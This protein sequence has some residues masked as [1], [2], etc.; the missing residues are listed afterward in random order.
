MMFSKKI[1]NGKSNIFPCRFP[2]TEMTALA[3]YKSAPRFVAFSQK[4]GM[5]INMKKRKVTL[6][7]LL[8][9][10]ATLLAIDSFKN[11]HYN[12]TQITTTHPESTVN[13]EDNAATKNF[14]SSSLPSIAQENKTVKFYYMNES[15]EVGKTAYNIAPYI[16]PRF[17]E[18]YDDK[19]EKNF[20]VYYADRVLGYQAYLTNV[21]FI[22]YDKKQNQFSANKAYSP[23]SITIDKNTDSL[24]LQ[25]GNYA[26][27]LDKQEIMKKVYK[28]NSNLK[29]ST[30]ELLNVGH[31]DLFPSYIQS[32]DLDGD[33]YEE[34]LIEYV[35]KNI[36]YG[37]YLTSILVVVDYK[38]NFNI[39]D[40]YCIDVRD[41]YS[42]KNAIA[43]FK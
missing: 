18:I 40:A 39:I 36:D 28:N 43:G 27:A 38:N 19:Y 8:F 30:D 22:R 21:S 25:D 42:Y 12:D 17:I 14:L 24:E 11:S 32:T 41:G 6:I 4:K 26:L 35:I 3:I 34:Y 31:I 7:I 23:L 20:I 13:C 16:E 5:V 9:I 1:S 37:V 2:K 15:I 33:G 29:L 10:I